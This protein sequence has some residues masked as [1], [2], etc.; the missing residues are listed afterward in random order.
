MILAS[1]SRWKSSAGP[2]QHQPAVSGSALQTRLDHRPSPAGR[3]SARAACSIAAS[4]P[5]R[6][7]PAG[8]GKARS[9]PSVAAM[10]IIRISLPSDHAVR[11]SSRQPMS[12]RWKPSAKSIASTAAIGARPGVGERVR[13]RGD[14]QHAPAAG[15][16]GAR[17]M[18]RGAGMEHRDARARSA[19]RCRRSRRPWPACR[20]SPWR[21]RSSSSSIARSSS[22]AVESPA[23]G[24][25]GHQQLGEVAFDPRHDRLAF[26][27]AEADIIFDQLGP[28]AVSI[29]PA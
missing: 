20:D 12:R 4:E 24:R 22:G 21:R 1:S 29:S 7:R 17:R 10:P 8:H 18:A 13:D 2:R 5:R 15:E 23:A 14:R 6:R 25:H 16:Q 11:S 27:I 28:S 3:A 26:G 19:A 9:T